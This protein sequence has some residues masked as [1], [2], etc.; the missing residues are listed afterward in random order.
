MKL[1]LAVDTEADNQ[2]ETGASLT[3]TNLE[4]V[5]RFQALCER[6]EFPPTYLCT[7]EVVTST[8]FNETLRRPTRAGRAEIGAHLHPWSTPP[9]DD[10]WDR[11]GRARTYPSEL[12]EDLLRAKLTSLTERISD[13]LGHRPT[14]C[15]TGRWGLS[16]SQVKA[17]CD[18]G[19][20][21]DCSVTP[22]VSWARDRGLRDGGP[23]F[24]RAPLAPYSPSKHDVCRAGSSELL[25]MP[26]T[27]V[28]TSGLMRRSR[29]LRRW[30]RRHRRC[31]DCCVSGTGA[32]SQAIPTRIDDEMAPFRCPLSLRE[33][34]GV[35]VRVS[36]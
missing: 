14:S 9:F 12:P 20:T 28:H 5:P 29:R 17:L 11:G 31:T 10:A 33:R 24:T 23:D 26:V 32:F 15:R 2:W 21:V 34:A 4:H 27:I 25:E 6:F 30:F 36:R 16:S 13:R 8:A 7:Y 1:I 19:Y 22:L 18:L 35:R 3:T